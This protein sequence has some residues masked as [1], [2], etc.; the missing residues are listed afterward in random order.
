MPPQQLDQDAVRLAKAIRYTESRDN[1]QAKGAS[2]EFGLYQW[3]PDTWAKTAKKYNLDPGDVSREN[4]NKAAY[5]TIKELKDS[6]K[7]PDQI[8]AFWN[9]GKTEGWEQN[10]GVNKYGVKYDTPD[11]VKKVGGVYTGLKT[12]DTPQTATTTSTVGAEQYGEKPRS[13]GENII[14]ADKGVVKGAG[15]TVA[16]AMRFGE[17][18]ANQTAGRVVSA[19]QGKGFN[20]LPTEELGGNIGRDKG[21]IDILKPTNTAQKVGYYG[22]K[23]GELALPGGAGGTKV[24]QARTAARAFDDALSVVA[25]KETANVI[26]QGLKQGRGVVQGFFREAGMSPDQTTERAARAVQGI[27]KKGATAAENSNAV[28]K[29]IG[30]TAKELVTKLKSQEIKPILA[31]HELDNLLSEASQKIGE[32]P[33]MVGNAGESAARIFKKFTSFLPKNKDITAEDLLHAR[34]Q[35]DGWMKS[36]KGAKVFDP[37]T[38]NAVSIALRTIRQGANDLVA[39]KAPDVAVKELLAKQSAMY[40]AL[41]N[42]AAKGVKEIGTTGPGRLA[43]KHPLLKQGLIKAAEY[44]G[45][46]AGLGLLGGKVFGER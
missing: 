39:T 18:V 8:A 38:E 43:A 34:Q 11:Y 25:P 45:L 5:M 23:V 9:S 29:G 24:L 13:L 40:D 7:R 16:G 36:I 12:S 41:E 28:L 21:L 26:K 15:D 31:P 19:I 17:T 4:Q 42:I 46:G 35:L 32:D 3:M 30:D 1:E 22:E 44:T 27:V 33:T 10:K 20:P 6:G 37:A 14:E 2:G